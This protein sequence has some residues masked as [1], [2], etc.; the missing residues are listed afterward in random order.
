MMR[1]LRSAVWFGVLVLML[2]TACA[3][4]QITS[5]WKDPSYQE[6]PRK[7][8]VIGIT[9]KPINKRIFEDEFVRQLKARNV[10]AVA[11]YTVMPDEKQNDHTVIAAK[12]KELDAD[13]VLISR[14]VSTKTVQYYVPGSTYYP[15]SYYGNCWDYYGYCS[16]AV[17][18]P[19][20]T[21][22]DEYA[23]MEINLYNARNDKLIW[24]ATS[25]TEILGSDQE[26]II[27]YI[28]VMVNAMAEHKL[29]K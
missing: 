20:Y 26:Q 23:L 7:I 15:P 21:A 25:E 24:S 1:T 14:L 13:V 18:T 5:A 2:F 16:Q 8:F 17:Y 3:T 27:S 9:K 19:G 22:E 11:S 29:L 4:T 28:N 10:N 12:V 6:Q